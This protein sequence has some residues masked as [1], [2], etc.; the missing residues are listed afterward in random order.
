MWG[1]ADSGHWHV[2]ICH[3]PVVVSLLQ[4]GLISQGAT[5]TDSRDGLAHK[6]TL[7]CCGR[8][9]NP[10]AAGSVDG[11]AWVQLGFYSLG[12]LYGRLT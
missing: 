12:L 1:W 8:R 3:L 2:T 5:P 7:H 11:S 4:H 10:I 9:V 6:H